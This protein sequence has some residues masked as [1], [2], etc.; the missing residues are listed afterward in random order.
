MNGKQSNDEWEREK[1]LSLISPPKIA[2]SP[3]T[4]LAVIDESIQHGRS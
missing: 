3:V 2:T 4:L 1:Y